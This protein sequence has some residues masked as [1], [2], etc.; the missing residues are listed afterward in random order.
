[1]ISNNTPLKWQSSPAGN[2]VSALNVNAAE[3]TQIDTGGNAIVFKNNSVDEAY[4]F[5]NAFGFV[6]TPFLLKQNTS[7]TGDTGAV[8]LLGGGANGATRGA[9]VCAYGNEGSSTGWLTLTTGDA[10]A[11]GLIIQ[12]ASS[13]GDIDFQTAGSNSRWK[14]VGSTGAL[15]AA[16]ANTAGLDLRGT[17]TTISMQEATAASACM[18]V[19]TPNGTTPVVVTTSCAVSGARVFFA[20]AGAVTNMGTIT[21]TTAANGTSFSFAS[22]G[23]SD[24]LASS[25]IYWIIKESA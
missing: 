20:R 25:V 9:G 7:D 11:A 23:A 19:A 8:C 2:P 12:N 16:T 4:L 5:D 18:G 3:Q 17:G 10:N 22:T 21:T 1:M 14:I 24:T 15:Q 6:G 13:N